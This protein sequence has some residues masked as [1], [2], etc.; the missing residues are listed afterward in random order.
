MN[1]AEFIIQSDDFGEDRGF[2]T[3]D[4]QYRE[5]KSVKNLFYKILLA[6]K[7][8]E[9]AAN[10]SED[11]YCN[12]TY[13]L[14]STYTA[15]DGEY[16]HN[17]FRRDIVYYYRHEVK[18]PIYIMRNRCHCRTCR[19]KYGYDSM[20]SITAQIETVDG[21][22]LVDVDVQMCTRCSSYFID[23]ESL[24][25]YEKEHGKLFFNREYDSDLKNEYSNFSFEKDTVLSRYGY[26]AGARAYD[27]ETRQGILAKLINEGISSKHEIKEILSRFIT[28]RGERCY[29]AIVLWKM[30]LMIVNGYKKDV[31]DVHSG[32]Y[33]IKK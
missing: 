16:K 25:E 20:K 14:L 3:T 21:R 4:V 29:N 7:I 9:C 19:N 17:R 32:F 18:K 22:K 6:E 31:Q 26:S 15:L 23:E 1:I 12:G 33:L 13:Y 8:M 30:D 24:K 5:K 28:L 11:F 2:I 10:E 27:N